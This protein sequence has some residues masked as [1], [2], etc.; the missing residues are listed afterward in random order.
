MLC[1]Y[2]Y[3]HKNAHAVDHWHLVGILLKFIAVDV[4]NISA[5]VENKTLL[6]K[7][8]KTGQKKIYHET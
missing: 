6:N 4:V 2:N 1:N 3:S 8:F 5:F 7:K